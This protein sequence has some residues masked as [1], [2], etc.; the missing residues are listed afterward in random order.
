VGRLY[1]TVWEA[2]IQPLLPKTL[3]WEGAASVSGPTNTTSR[4]RAGKGHY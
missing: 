3:Q 4:W 1:T 2:E